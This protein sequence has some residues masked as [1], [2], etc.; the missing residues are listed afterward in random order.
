MTVPARPAPHESATP[1]HVR[2]GGFWL[3]GDPHGG[4]G[5]G[6]GAPRQLGPAWVQWEAPAYLTGA[7]PMVFV[8]GGGGQSTDWLG[9]A[10]APEGWAHHAVRAGFPAYLLD[11]P[12]HG[13]SPWD[14]ALLGGRTPSPGYPGL[15]AV[16]VPDDGDPRAGA[17]TA[18]PW[19]RGAGDAEVDAQVASSAGMLLDTA[20]GQELDARRLVD[21][22]ERTGPAV[23]VTHSAGAPAGWLAADRRPELVLAVVAVEPIGPPYKDLGPRGSLS[24]GPTA[25]PLTWD[26]SEPTPRLSRLART[27]VCVVSGSASGRAVDDRVTVSF[28]RDGGVATHH[29]EL[30]AEGLPGNGHG[31]IFESTNREIFDLLARWVSEAVGVSV[32]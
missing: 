16:F 32:P 12:G 2:R 20:L 21:L 1:V 25:V 6:D 15:A 31:L 26:R 30:A 10:G 28:L 13:R 29:V 23:V 5:H 22:L 7:P 24:E 11:R 4:D 19:G 18:W 14:P 8:H 17:H 27:P 3:P 9:T